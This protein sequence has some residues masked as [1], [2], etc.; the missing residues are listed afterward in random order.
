VT[1][2]LLDAMARQLITGASF[3]TLARKRTVYVRFTQF[4]RDFF[5]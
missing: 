4:I 3:G 2:S 1:L 5:V